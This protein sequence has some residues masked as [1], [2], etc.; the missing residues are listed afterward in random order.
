M[1]TLFRERN[2]EQINLDHLIKISRVEF[3][4]REPKVSFMEPLKTF[5]CIV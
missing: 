5:H 4:F 3:L 1:P 2:K